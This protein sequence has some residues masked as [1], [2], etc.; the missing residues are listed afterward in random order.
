MKNA[1]IAVLGMFDGVHVGHQALLHRASELKKETSLPVK[2]LTFETHPKALF[3]QPPVM[4][5]NN[6]QKEK[7]CL[8]Y[9]VDEVIFLPFDETM[10]MMGAEQFVSEYLM[11]QWNAKYVVV[12][13]NY[14]FGYCHTGNVTTLIKYQ[15]FQTEVV[16]SV[17]LNG[18]TVS[19]SRIRTLLADGNLDLALQCLGHSLE[20]EGMVE[21]GRCVGR[22]LGF[23]TANI[24]GEFPPLCSGVYL[25]KVMVGDDWFPAISNFGVLP[26]F[27]LKNP[28]KLESHLLHFEGDLYDQK[29]LVQFLEFVRKEKR[30]ESS[31]QLVAQIE[32]D[33]E[34]AK[35]YFKN[36]L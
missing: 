4:L 22:T 15:E 14:R 3:G 28:P 11:N 7:L 2:L 19:S 8:S 23:R 12:G 25:T 10:R 1:C 18:E 32:E 29:I 9:G 20:F 6:Q 13:E 36:A 5:T 35:H 24:S 17:C 16:S 27:D 34:Y 26:T 21:R 30:F 33:I 31:E